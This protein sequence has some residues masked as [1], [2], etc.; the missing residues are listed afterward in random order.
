MNRR[1]LAAAVLIFGAVTLSAACSSSSADDDAS[2]PQVVTLGKGDV[3]PQIHNS[4]LAVGENR[5]SLGLTD[6]DGNNILGAGVHLQFY[7]LTGEKPQL[8]SETDCDVC[9]GRA[10]VYR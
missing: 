10:L 9:A 8:R 5:L 2:F 7:D 1:A 6:R 4:T 3:F